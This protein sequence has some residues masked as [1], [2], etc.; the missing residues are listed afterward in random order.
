MIPVLVVDD[1]EANL[2]LYARVLQQIPETQAF[3][4]TSSKKGLTW[5][6]Q[7]D[8]ALV[9]LD[10]NMPDPDGLEMIR[11]YRRLPGRGDTPIIMITG[12]AERDVRREAMKRGASAF[13]Q[14]P[15]DP[16]EFLFYARNLLSVRQQRID[17]ALKVQQLTFQI[18]DLEQQVVARERDSLERLLRAYE[19]RDRRSYEH[20]LRVGLFAERIAKAGG[21]SADDA[22][23]LGFAAQVHDIGK[24]MIPDRVLFKNGRLQPSERESVNRHAAA[25]ETIL[26]SAG[27]SKLFAFA[28]E[29][30]ANHHEHFDGTGYP[31]GLKGDA[32]PE[33][34]RIVAVADR[35]A[36]STA[37]RP[38]RDANAF[39]VGVGEVLRVSG[40]V[41]DPKWVAAFRDALNEI[42]LARSRVPDLKLV[43]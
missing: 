18:R 31:K 30:A 20:G 3:C 13:L 23:N 28:A 12:S 9:V 36:A 5:A 11:L 19:A 40:T 6:E 25:G 16:V 1:Y 2:T 26:K 38:W 32:I 39:D 41:F 22:A 27:P 21:M 17:A 34:A 35:F 8:P 24:I 43:P 37:H 14:K 15:V 4:F 29:I 7:Y 10:Q 33:S 42:K